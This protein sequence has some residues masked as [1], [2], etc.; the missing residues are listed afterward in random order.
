MVNM[1]LI[2]NILEPP[3]KTCKRQTEDQMKKERVYTFTTKYLL[4][5][6]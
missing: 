5:I 6:K 1:E 2:H 4:N 3:L